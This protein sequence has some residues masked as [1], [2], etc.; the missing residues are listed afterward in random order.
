MQRILLVNNV[1]KI[2]IDR[3]KKVLFLLALSAIILFSLSWVF[4]NFAL[5]LLGGAISL[6]SLSLVIRKGTSLILTAISLLVGW[7]LVEFLIPFIPITDS[8]TAELHYDPNCGYSNHYFRKNINGLGYLPN[9]GSYTSRRLDILTGEEIYNVTYTIGEDGFRFSPDGDRANI[10]LMGGSFTFGEGLEDNETLS[11]YMQ[12][13]SGKPVKNFGIHG[14]GMHQALYILENLY[15]APENGTVILQTAPW[16]ALRSAGKFYYDCTKGSA[17]Y[18]LTG[19]YVTDV[20]TWKRYPYL[21]YSR[22]KMWPPIRELWFEKI[23]SNDIG[24]YLGIIRTI[25]RETH[26]SGSKLLI[27]FIKSRENHF[28]SFCQWD[29]QSIMDELSSF[30]DGFVDVTLAETRE[31]LDPKFYLH[32][33][34]EHPSALANE[35]RAKLILQAME[36]L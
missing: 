17:K 18:K 14:Y 22:S 6:S 12:V 32:E 7:A 36:D 11:H 29:N 31:A 15:P 13:S 2:E 16:H 34:D 23:D 8:P 10:Y 25:A 21:I 5:L 4:R 20:G 33:Y 1:I 26:K 28:R 19:N 3:N 30:A 35:V 24:L 9:P 27:A